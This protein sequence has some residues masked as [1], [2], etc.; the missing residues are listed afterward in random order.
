MGPTEGPQATPQFD[1][2]QALE[3]WFARRRGVRRPMQEL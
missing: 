2:R 1:T 3:R